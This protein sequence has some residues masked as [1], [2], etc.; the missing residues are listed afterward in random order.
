MSRLLTE[1]DSDD[2]VLTQ[3]N[4]LEL[5]TVLVSVTHGRQYLQQSGVLEQLEDKLVNTSSDPLAQLLQPGLCLC[6]SLSVCLC[7]SLSVCLCLSLSVCIHVCVRVC[8]SV[9]IKWSCQT[10]PI[11]VWAGL[12]LLVTGCL[13]YALISY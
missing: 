1:L 6:L 10:L 11:L 12:V 5:M 7:L 9:K 3:L 13:H 2:D 8:L 4:C